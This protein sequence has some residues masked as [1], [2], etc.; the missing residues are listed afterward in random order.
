M[1]AT[2]FITAGYMELPA[3]HKLILMK[4]ADSA[5]DRSR[6]GYPGLDALRLWAGVSRS[7]VLEV[8]VD[9]QERGLLMQVEGG[10]RGR[11]A[12]FKV[13]PERG[14]EVRSTAHKRGMPCPGAELFDGSPGI[15]VDGEVAALA[16]SRDAARSRKGSDGQ[17][18]SN[19]VLRFRKS[20]TSRTQSADEGSY[21]PDPSSTR[22]GP[23]DTEKGSSFSDLGSDRQ[24]PF[25]TNLRNQ[26]TSEE[27]ADADAPTPPAP[28]VLPGF[29]EPAPTAKAKPKDPLATEAQRITRMWWESLEYEPTSGDAFRNTQAIVLRSLRNRRPPAV[30]EEAL[31]ACGVSVTAKSLD[32]QFSIIDRLRNKQRVR[33]AQS[34]QSRWNDENFGFGMP[35]RKSS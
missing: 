19:R 2:L 3:T 10:H 5:D 14:D 29:D 34:N 12:S 20:P 32:T 31:I 13:F 4:I 35:E 24:D 25:G 33:P 11:R 6:V 23:V 7:R 1:S 28:T 22:K 27:R 16:D 18:P 17:D 30:V 21:P 15:P 9:L 8:V 26:S